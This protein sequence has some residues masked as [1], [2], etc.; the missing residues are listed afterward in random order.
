MP[1]L[2]N[3]HVAF[4]TL[5][6]TVNMNGLYNGFKG[7]SHRARI[8]NWA[9]I[10]LEYC[11]NSIDECE[12]EMNIADGIFSVNLET[13]DVTVRHSLI[14]HRLFDRAI[15]NCFTLTRKNTT[16][17]LSKDFHNLIIKFAEL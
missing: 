17:V 2:G 14:V 11:E 7:E 8:P 3:G 4:T 13:E 1:Q 6:R 5:S 12:Y 9:N 10:I 16:S 15:V